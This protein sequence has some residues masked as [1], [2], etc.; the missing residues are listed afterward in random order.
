MGWLTKGRAYWE[1]PSSE[2]LGS[3]TTGFGYWFCGRCNR[4][5]ASS[6]KT[7]IEEHTIECNAKWAD[8][9]VQRAYEKLDW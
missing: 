3:T 5:I 2:S 1:K 4:G 9:A 8:E 7:E 6:E